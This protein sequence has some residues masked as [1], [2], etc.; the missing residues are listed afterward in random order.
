LSLDAPREGIA[1]DGTKAV[2]SIVIAW[3][4]TGPG[5]FPGFRISDATTDAPGSY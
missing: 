3:V 5:N 2:R 1:P 4:G